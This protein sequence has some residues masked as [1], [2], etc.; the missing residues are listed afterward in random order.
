VSFVESMSER[1]ADWQGG[2]SEHIGKIRATSDAAGRD[3]RQA[4]WK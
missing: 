3:A 1:G 4:L 2:T